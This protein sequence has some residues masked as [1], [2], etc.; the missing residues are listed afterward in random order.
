MRS[1]PRTSGIGTVAGKAV[2][3]SIRSRGL[4]I[5][6]IANRAGTSRTTVSRIL[7][8]R[9]EPHNLL[10]VL[11]VLTDAEIQVLGHWGTWTAAVPPERVG[12]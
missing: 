10:A 8:A 9:S 11:A 5:Q 2:A 1:L 3:K 7:N 12:K 4:T 6:D